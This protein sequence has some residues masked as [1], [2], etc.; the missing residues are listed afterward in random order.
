MLNL[1][2]VICLVSVVSVCVR[3]EGG[4]VRVFVRGQKERRCVHLTRT[5]VTRILLRIELLKTN[6]QYHVHTY[7]KSKLIAFTYTFSNTSIKCVQEQDSPSER[8]Y[9]SR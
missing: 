5:L 2:S 7:T 9:L 6:K 8:R 3:D 4:G 1:S